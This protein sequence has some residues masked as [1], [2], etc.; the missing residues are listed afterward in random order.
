MKMTKIHKKSKTKHAEMAQS[1]SKKKTPR[2][3][4]VASALGTEGNQKKQKNKKY[5]FFVVLLPRGQPTQP[6]KQSTAEILLASSAPRARI[7][8][9]DCLRGWVGCIPGPR[10]T[11]SVC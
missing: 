3:E 6:F 9:V 10:Q 4:N 1:V 2:R 8:A 5:V 7:F 11:Y